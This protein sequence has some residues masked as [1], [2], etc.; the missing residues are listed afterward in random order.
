MSS[1]Y[2][3]GKWWEAFILSFADMKGRLRN[4]GVERSHLVHSK[5]FDDGPPETRHLS[6]EV[7]CL[8][9][10]FTEHRKKKTSLHTI[11]EDNGGTLIGSDPQAFIGCG[12]DSYL[13]SRGVRTKGPYT[14]AEIVRAI[15]ISADYWKLIQMEQ[16]A[17]AIEEFKQRYFR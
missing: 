17:E 4:Q 2:G 7:P 12:M 9:M 8:P 3:K 15:D 13:K 16:C 11:R 5:F 14:R 6:R 10:T 1:T